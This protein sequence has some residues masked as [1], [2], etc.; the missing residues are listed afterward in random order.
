VRAFQEKLAA[1]RGGSQPGDRRAGQVHAGP[2]GAGNGWGKREIRNRD[3]SNSHN[4]FGIKAG[5]GWKGK[6]ATAVTTEYV[7]GKPHTRVERFRA[8]DSYATA[9]RITPSCCRIIRA[10]KKCWPRAAT[11]P[12][13]A[14]GL[15][16]AGYATDPQYA[17]KLSRIIKHSLAGE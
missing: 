11:P 13:F 7:N 2:G 4:L 1:P 10:T 5:P 14:H 8:Y 17:A 3:G 12:A 6:V 16:R 15:Q 9:S